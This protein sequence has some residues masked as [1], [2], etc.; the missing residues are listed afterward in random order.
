MALAPYS[1]RAREA[2][3]GKSSFSY[4]SYLLPLVILA[5]AVRAARDGEAA[6]AAEGPAGAAAGQ[7]DAPANAGA[8]PGLMLRRTTSGSWRS[9]TAR[10]GRARRAVAAAATTQTSM[11]LSRTPAKSELCHNVSSMPSS[12]T[13]ASVRTLSG[14]F[15]DASFTTSVSLGE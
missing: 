9:T 4:H 7:P 2:G 14:R 8:R 10:R 1:S 3:P 12:L 11:L 13:D 15:D 5:Q 6:G